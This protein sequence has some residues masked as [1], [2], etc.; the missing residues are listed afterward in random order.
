MNVCASIAF[1]ALWFQH[2]QMKPEICGYSHESFEIVKRRL[3]KI[4]GHTF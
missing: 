3:S 4:L 1:A 2:S